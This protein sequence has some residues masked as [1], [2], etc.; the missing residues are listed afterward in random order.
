M[1]EVPPQRLLQIWEGAAQ[2]FS[3]DSSLEDVK[4][5]EGLPIAPEEHM[6]GPLSQRGSGKRK[7]DHHLPEDTSDWD[8]MGEGQLGHQLGVGTCGT[9]AGTGCLTVVQIESAQVH[10]LHMDPSCCSQE[11]RT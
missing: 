7:S 2:W 11:T 3:F 1:G 8:G 9:G 5:V 4:W 10:K 6:M